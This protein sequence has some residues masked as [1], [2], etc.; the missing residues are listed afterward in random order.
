MP[1]LVV[2]QVLGRMGSLRFPWPVRHQQQQ[3]GTMWMT[4]TCLHRQA[5]ALACLLCDK[6][7]LSPQSSKMRL[8]GQK[9][10]VEEAAG[11]LGACHVCCLHPG[12]SYVSVFS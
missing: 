11:L 9:S 2:Q 6:H 7:T 5:G 1:S 10:G 4:V 8:W 12:G 3:A